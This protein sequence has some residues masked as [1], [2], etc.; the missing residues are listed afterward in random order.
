MQ[1]RFPFLISPMSNNPK[2]SARSAAALS[3]SSVSNDTKKTQS[4]SQDA[5]GNEPHP[6]DIYEVMLILVQRSSG[7]ALIEASSLEDAR[8]KA[9]EI[10]LE[11]A[12]NWEVFEDTLLVE[13][14][15]PANGAQNH[16]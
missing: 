15:E 10:R 16:E 14:V 7:K 6:A 1:E 9:E 8:A 12:D 3:D 5:A 11:E 2:N 13:S 4:C